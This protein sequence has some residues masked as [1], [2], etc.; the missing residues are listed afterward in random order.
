VKLSDKFRS[1]LGRT[2]GR[3]PA[4]LEDTRL[5][6]VEM[7]E[8]YRLYREIAAMQRELLKPKTIQKGSGAARRVHH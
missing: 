1:L 3:D 6:R 8:S 4:T 2:S 5:S 7:T